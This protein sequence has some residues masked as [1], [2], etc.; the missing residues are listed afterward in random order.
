M[1]PG[2]TLIGYLLTTSTAPADVD[3]LGS[4]AE[5]ILTDAQSLATEFSDLYGGFVL[6]DSYYRGEPPLPREPVRLTSKYRE[7]LQMGVSN[8]CA[9]VV[10]VVNERL[11]V[12][13]IISTEHPA[14]D[15]VAWSWW[16]ANNMDQH[17][18]TIHTA[19]LTYGCCYVSVWPSSDAQGNPDLTA[20][21]IIMGESP[22]TTHVRINDATGTACCAFRVWAD[23]QTGYLYA[24]YTNDLWQFRLKSTDPV[25]PMPFGKFNDRDVLTTDLSHVTWTF[26]EDVAP[27][28]ANPLGVVPYAK[29]RTQPDLLGGYRSEIAG[30]LPIQ[31][32]INKT[33]FD[34][35]ITQEFAAFPQRW[36]TGIDVPT[37]PSTQKPVEPFNAAVDRIWTSSDPDTKMG[38]FPP[39][40]LNGYL[41]AIT[42]DVQALATQSRTPPHYLLAGMGQF[43]SGES[44]RATEYGLTRKVQARQVS[45][46]DTWGDV[47]RLCALAVG[48]QQR[49]N[50]PRLNVTW[51]DVEARSEAETVDALVKMG[52]LGVPADALWQRWGASAEEIAAWSKAIQEAPDDP[53]KQV[54][55]TVP[56]A[57]SAAPAAPAQIPQADRP[58]L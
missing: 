51:A 4:M 27:L 21:P 14:R 24:D 36:V 42:A 11:A 12:S 8:W 29:L 17:S 10:D 25:Q 56:A 9:L 48:D 2:D 7:L 49:A 53:T 6:L 1:T 19:A 38:Q 47:L 23:R 50:D 41:A 16:T 31:D 55:V 45:Y 46:G 3:A 28:R 58:R 20:P 43:P 40:D 13:S 35:L 33:N 30:V 57:G 37:D 54:T 34:R 18:A 22:L 39:A 44:V 52:S 32:R 5:V 15:P 26:R